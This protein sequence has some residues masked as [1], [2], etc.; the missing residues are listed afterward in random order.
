VPAE[1]VVRGSGGRERPLT[2]PGAPAE[3]AANANAPAPRI[4][5]DDTRQLARLDDEVV[6]PTDHVEDEPWDQ[7]R[8]NA[9]VVPDTPPDVVKAIDPSPTP[10]PTRRTPS[11]PGSTSKPAPPPSSAPPSSSVASNSGLSKPARP[12]PPDEEPPPVVE[13]TG[14]L[15]RRTFQPPPAVAPPVPADGST[16]FAA[17]TPANGSPPPRPAPEPVRRPRVS[18]EPT[19]YAWFEHVSEGP[20]EEPPVQVNPA[21]VT[22]PEPA[23]AVPPEP[24]WPTEQAAT[25]PA[26]PPRPQGVQN[27]AGLP[28]RVPKAGLFPTTGAPAAGPA[29]GAAHRDPNRTRGFLASYQ[30][31]IRQDHTG[32]AASNENERGQENP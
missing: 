2:A 25:P 20:T 12:A 22:A 29:A 23:P 28:K 4:S 10:L 13:S 30:S 8:R 5:P 18:L 16:W 32:A 21:G 17:N 31:G 9:P 27:G 11:K 1:L 14:S 6:W 19:R 3:P 24:T 15:P 26:P 7:P